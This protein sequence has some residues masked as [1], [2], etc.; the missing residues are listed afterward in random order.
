MKLFSWLIRL[1]NEAQ[2]AR[3][4]QHGRLADAEAYL[5]KSWTLA[6]S[7]SPTNRARARILELLTKVTRNQGNIDDAESFGRHWLEACEKIYGHEDVR[8]ARAAEYLAEIYVAIARY[9][10]A[11]PLLER[12]LVVREKHQG[13]EPLKHVQ[14]LESLGAFWSSQERDDKAEPYLRCALSVALA[15]PE[16]ITEARTSAC[17]LSKTLV[18][19]HR[20][21]EAENVAQEALAAAQKSYSGGF[22]I[23]DCLYQLAY[24]RRFQERFE[25][26]ED[27]VRRSLTMFRQALV[28]AMSGAPAGESSLPALVERMSHPHVQLLGVVLRCQS[29]WAEAEE[30]FRTVLRVR[31]DYLAPE[32]LAIAR[33][34]EDY[35]ELLELMG[36]TE[37]A[38]VHQRWA[39]HIR[40]FHAPFRIQ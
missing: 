5:R 8:T 28:E 26:A 35:A 13:R 27:L 14:A 6:E 17:C 9:H 22:P 36:R 4:Y 32:D 10:L 34:L 24:V 18:H 39:R 15:M 11:A 2:G 30:C 29:R 1:Y 23:A 7:L 19:L 31:Q 38:N 37:D 33:V 12:A 3:A 40:D 20:L 25:E 21:D 16:N